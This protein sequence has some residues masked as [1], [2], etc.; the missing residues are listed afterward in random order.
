MIK[1]T[2]ESGFSYKISDEVRDDMELLEA[3]MRVDGGD[4]GAVPIMLDMLLG[5]EQKEKLYEHCRV[6]KEVKKGSEKVIEK[7]RVS[8]TAVLK[9]I[10]CIFEGMK[11]QN[12]KVKN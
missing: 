6:K 3:I 1:G 8:A 9:E 10:R 12:S 5:K 2:T 4:N 11:D 7:G